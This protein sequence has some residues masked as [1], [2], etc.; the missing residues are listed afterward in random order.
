M[1][2]DSGDSETQHR[3]ISSRL[4]KVNYSMSVS[5]QS[6]LTSSLQSLETRKDAQN[7]LNSGEVCRIR[8]NEVNYLGDIM[9]ESSH[10]SRCKAM[11][12][13]IQKIKPITGSLKRKCMVTVH[14]LKQEP[15]EIRI[16]VPT[17]G[18]IPASSIE[19]SC[20]SSEGKDSSIAVLCRSIWTHI[21][22]RWQTYSRIS[23][24]ALCSMHC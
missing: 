6:V 5:K 2:S 16:R 22:F 12:I 21:F 8:N 15:M 9:K 19:L 11:I 1:E 10:C 4:L 13:I 14:C 18:R 7:T 24:C 20:F 17:R 3:G 23:K